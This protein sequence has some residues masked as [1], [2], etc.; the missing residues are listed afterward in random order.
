MTRKTSQKTGEQN[1][2]EFWLALQTVVPMELP[3]VLG[4]APGS[5][6]KGYWNTEGYSLTA[7][8]IA[9]LTVA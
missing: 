4:I 3:T 6:T 7:A 1:K 2:P 5:K 8:S 9:S